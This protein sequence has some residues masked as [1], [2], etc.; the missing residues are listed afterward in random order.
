M[1][2]LPSSGP[3]PLSQ[4][5][6]LAIVGL[7]CVVLALGL[8][9][10]FWAI[11]R[12]DELALRRQLT[13][14]ATGMT[15][16]FETVPVDQESATVWSASIVALRGGDADFVAGNLTEWMGSYFGFEAVYVLDPA[17][18]PRH[19]MEAGETVSSAAYFWVKG[20]VNPLVQQLRDE[21]RGL[22]AAGTYDDEIVS[23]GVK[24]I[25][26][27]AGQPAIVSVKPVIPDGDD[28]VQ[29]A[30]SEYLHIAVDH[31]DSAL[32]TEIGEHFS[33]AG[34][35][36]T[37]AAPDSA[38]GAGLPILN[39]A[40][41]TLGYFAWDRDRPGLQLAAELAPGGIITILLGL[42]ALGRLLRHLRQATTSLQLS[43]AHAQHL[44]YH[45][46]LTGLTNRALFEDRLD[47]ALAS[48]RRGDNRLAL[49]FIDLDRFK[50]IND[51][52][53]HPA[54]DELI[55]QA[56]RRLSEIVREVDTV[57]RLGGDEFAIIQTNI[58]D[59]RDAVRL[60]ER[61]LSTLNEPFDLLGE[62]AYVSASIGITLSLSEAADRDEMLRKA[63]IAL[64]EAKAKGRSRYEIFDGDMDEVVR[65][66]RTIERDLR[67]AVI[68]GEELEVFYQPLY[69]QDGA[70]I[71][72]AEALL[73]WNHPV[74][75]KLS[76][77]LFIGI[78]EERGLIEPLGEWVL[79]QACLLA[80]GTTI[81]WVAVNV[82]PVQFRNEYFAERV[83]AI[84]RETGIAP[85]RIQLEITEGVLLT[86]TGQV[87]TALR[88]L[89]NAGVMVAL[90][91]FGTGYS[92]MNYLNRFHVDKLKIDKSF[93]QRLGKSEDSDALVRAIISMAR[94][95]RMQ[96]TGEGVETVAQRQQL[97]DMGCHE[98]QGYL[99]ARPMPAA[100]LQTLLV[101]PTQA[102]R[103]RA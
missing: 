34:A 43:E 80:A 75:G 10:T 73:R 22:V 33:L 78:A 1:R 92:S 3:K 96:V 5:L 11:S 41:D 85:K 23:L 102:D 57:A 44:A 21:V 83:L 36:Y 89:R 94:A 81:P 79:R 82:S 69:D 47:H 25:V 56:A 12:T 103:Q 50:N 14:G 90:D 100:H 4:R 6:T 24:D 40:G 31:I 74:H 72:G 88:K 91:D 95:M 38:W 77:E 59:D 87:E 70:T 76:P 86:N 60:C 68:T 7:V 13:L 49:L 19:A 54:G 42:L 58:R 63:D 93:V 99:M 32:V 20:V 67:R 8:M 29:A 64:Y 55:R 17:N 28:V 18:Q 52:L 62:A 30:G 37:R 16:A 101:N 84:I 26:E 35:R 65:R 97:A 2:S 9:G 15:E 45:D 46:T 53:G 71:L 48:V 98:V 27:I 66:R 39:S 51:T 61:I